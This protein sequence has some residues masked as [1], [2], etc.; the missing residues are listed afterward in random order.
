MQL[1]RNEAHCLIDVFN[2]IGYSE[3]ITRHAH[4]IGNTAYCVRNDRHGSQYQVG[5]A[6]INKLRAL[7]EREADALLTK[8]HAFWNCD[9]NGNPIPDAEYCIP[10]TEQRLIQVGLIDDTAEVSMGQETYNLAK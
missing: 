9:P 1:E 3:G 7:T 5:E 10:D 6:F 2:G 8:I 4:L